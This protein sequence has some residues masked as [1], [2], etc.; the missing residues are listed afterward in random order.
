[1]GTFEIAQLDVETAM[2][3]RLWSLNPHEVWH[4]DHL[5]EFIERSRLQTLGMTI[6]DECLWQ[7]TGGLGPPPGGIWMTD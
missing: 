3:E 4:S 2:D 6:G 7:V 1:M 5:T